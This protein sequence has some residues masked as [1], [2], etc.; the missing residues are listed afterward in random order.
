[1]SDVRKWDEINGLSEPAQRME[2]F[3]DSATDSYAILQLRNT[4][5]PPTS[6][7]NPCAALPGR[8]RSPDIDHY[9]VVYCGPLTLADGHTGGDNCDTGRFVRPVQL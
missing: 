1:M 2:A 6:G 7:M 5:I 8:A 9:E 4:Q 3:L